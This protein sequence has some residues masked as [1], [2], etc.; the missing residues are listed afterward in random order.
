MAYWQVTT[1]KLFFF[2][3]AG[4]SFDFLHSQL[5]NT[6]FSVKNGLFFWHPLL[7]LAIPGFYYW[8]KDSK[9][10][11]MSKISLLFLVVFIYIM[12]CWWAWWFGYAFGMRPFTDFFILFFIPIG[13]L[14]IRLKKLKPKLIILFVFIICLF[15]ALNLIQ[16]NN[17][18]RGIVAGNNLSIENYLNNF[19]N[20][21]IGE[22]IDR[23]N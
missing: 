8:L 5:F 17:Y 10:K 20:P 23:S 9:D 13:Y 3:Y 14:F 1:G 22:L 19:A 12:S 11:Y 15:F 21:H 2:G 16:M 6:L 4:E 18:W 7:L